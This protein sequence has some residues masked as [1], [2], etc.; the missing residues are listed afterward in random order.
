V[1]G[2]WRAYTVFRGTKVAAPSSSRYV[3]WRVIE[4]LAD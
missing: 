4:P 2:T 1:L 3:R